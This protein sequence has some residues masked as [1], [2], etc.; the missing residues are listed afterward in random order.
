MSIGILSVPPLV[1]FP[2]RCTLALLDTLLVLRLLRRYAHNIWHITYLLSGGRWRCCCS[3]VFF[4][5]DI[6]HTWVHVRPLFLFVVFPF[7]RISYMSGLALLGRVLVVYP[8]RGA[9]RYLFILLVYLFPRCACFVGF[10]RCAASRGEATWG[11]IPFDAGLC[12]L[13]E[14]PLPLVKWRTQPRG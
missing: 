12:A 14:L 3:C 2:C 1:G 4:M 9:V 7:A 13:S 10:S 6:Q 8:H 11:N 5:H